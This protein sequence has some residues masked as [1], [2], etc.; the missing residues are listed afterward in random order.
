MFSFHSTLRQR[1]SYFPSIIGIISLFFILLVCFLISNSIIS[2]PGV[3]VELPQM[4]AVEISSADKLIVTIAGNGDIFFNGSKMDMAKLEESLK[5][6]AHALLK[7]QKSV[8]GGANAGITRNPTIVL[9]ADRHIGLDPCAKIMD[10]ARE[11]G[12]EVVL[13]AERPKLPSTVYRT[14][15]K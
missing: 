6:K 11:N 9:C 1:P 10:I 2:W 14:N 13:V 15:E 4:N 3:T 7:A 5:G 12:M 8:S